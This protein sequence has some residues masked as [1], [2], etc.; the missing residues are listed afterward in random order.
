MKHWSKN[1]D[2]I[3]LFC[4]RFSSVIP[5]KTRAKRETSPLRVNGLSPVTTWGDMTGEGGQC[6]TSKAAYGQCKSFKS[7]YPYFKKVPELGV[8]D[9]WVLGQYD[10]CTYFTKEGRQAFGVCCT[11][12]VKPSDSVNIY[13][14]YVNNW[15]PPLP[16][17]PPNHAAP[18][19]PPISGSFPAGIQTTTK[20]PYYPW[21]PA[22]P[23][24]KPVSQVTTRPTTPKPPPPSIQSDVGDYCGAKNGNQD[25]ERIVG[26]QQASPNEWPWVAVL[27][28]N[29]RQFCGGSLIDHNHIL[30]AAHCVAQYVDTSRIIFFFSNRKLI[31]FSHDFQYECMG[32]GKIDCTIGRS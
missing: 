8:F 17:H 19:H 26:G 7:C 4:F 32:C 24:H 22:L 16:T 23:T 11:D 28:N 18:T 3:F 5:K 15:P 1:S 27:F 25:Q 12:S 21:P 29:G 20:N 6:V 10:T 13:A 2:S 14:A 9:S 30:T 31:S